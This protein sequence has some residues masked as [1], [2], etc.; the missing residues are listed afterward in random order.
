MQRITVQVLLST[1]K[2]FF[3]FSVLS[4]FAW[5][6][7]AVPQLFWFHCSLTFHVKCPLLWVKRILKF[8]RDQHT[9]DKTKHFNLT[10][11]TCKFSCICQLFGAWQ[12]ELKY[13]AV[14]SNL[15]CGLSVCVWIQVPEFSFIVNWR[16]LRVTQVALHSST[17]W[18]TLQ[19][20]TAPH[21]LIRTTKTE[22]IRPVFLPRLYL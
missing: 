4:T 22:V 8:V 11:L 3:L 1:T 17:E 15:F 18:N 12:Q 16:Y 10:S 6:N 21:E 5:H 13:T 9:V 7:T 20:A 14:T 19:M 2:F